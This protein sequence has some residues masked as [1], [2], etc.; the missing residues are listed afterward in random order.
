ME[1]LEQRLIFEN[2]LDFSGN[3]YHR[4]LDDVRTPVGN[5]ALL[6]INKNIAACQA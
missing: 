1:S 6:L 5:Y 2:G 4:M 3:E